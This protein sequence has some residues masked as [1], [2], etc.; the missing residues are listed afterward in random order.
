MSKKMVWI[1]CYLVFWGSLI[2]WGY[3]E[4]FSDRWM[5]WVLVIAGTLG[6]IA[7]LVPPL[8]A[9]TPSSR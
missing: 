1:V 2:T 3:V 9:S 4:G 6:L 7:F 8:A 5:I